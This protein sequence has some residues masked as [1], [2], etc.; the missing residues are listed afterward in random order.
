MKAAPR[1][2]ASGNTVSTSDDDDQPI[3]ME[4]KFR[5]MVTSIN[6]LISSNKKLDEALQDSYDDDDLLDALKENEALI[7]RKIYEATSLAANL[8]KH[9]VHI[10]LADKILQYDGSSVLKRLEADQKDKAD[11][12]AGDGIYL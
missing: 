4:A 5:E 2:T 9:G 3:L 1:L 8:N 7:H 11:K 12:N 10:S 6:Q